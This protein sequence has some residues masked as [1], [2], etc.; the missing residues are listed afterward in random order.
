MPASAQT[1][2]VTAT[3]GYINLGMT[4]SIAVTAPAAGTYTAVVV[5]PDGSSSSLPYAFTAGGKTQASVFGNATSGFG[6]L[7]NQVGT[8]NVFVE[9]GSAVMGTTSFYATNKI[10]ITMDMVTG[11]TCYFI[12]SDA[13]GYKFI[14]RFYA[15]YASTGALLSNLTPG[16]K[17]DVHSTRRQDGLDRYVGHRR[18]PL[19]GSRPAGL[20]LYLHRTLEPHRYGPGLLRERRYV[21]LRRDPVHDNG[22]HTLDEHPDD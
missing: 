2:I 17:I 15:S 14:P 7:V 22:C 10:V 9:Q 13:R 5:K 6:T 3:P 4:T 16:V 21:H 19:Q 8:Y 12:N 1:Q 18:A 20:E 11:G